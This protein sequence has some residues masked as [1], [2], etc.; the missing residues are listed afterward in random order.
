MKY[1]IIILT[2]VATSAHAQERYYEKDYRKPIQSYTIMSPT[3][4]Y[5]GT[6]QRQGDTWNLYTPEDGYQGMMQRD[7][8]GN[9]NM[10]TPGGGYQG[11]LYPQY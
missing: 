8:S 10:Y 2:L 4:G 3:E 9:W 7:G 5:Q 1:L 6:W 11:T